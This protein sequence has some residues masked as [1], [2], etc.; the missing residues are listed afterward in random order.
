[1][2]QVFATS[3]RTTHSAICDAVAS[4]TLVEYLPHR[5]TQNPHAIDCQTSSIRCVGPPG[6]FKLMRMS[7]SSLGTKLSLQI[8]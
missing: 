3:Q 4:K 1:V 8:L 5:L 2:V 6:F 7:A